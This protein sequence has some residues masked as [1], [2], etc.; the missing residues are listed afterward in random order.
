MISAG[1]PEIA[2]ATESISTGLPPADDKPN[3]R[4]I[5]YSRQQRPFGSGSARLGLSQKDGLPVPLLE[6]IW[7]FKAI[8]ART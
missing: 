6:S 4:P 3:Y 5:Y 7:R 8:D 1:S 2:G